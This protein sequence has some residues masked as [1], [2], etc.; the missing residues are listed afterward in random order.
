[1]QI[2]SYFGGDAEARVNFCREG[3]SRGAFYTLH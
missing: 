2:W 1:M 3:D